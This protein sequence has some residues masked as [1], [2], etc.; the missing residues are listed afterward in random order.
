MIQAARTMTALDDGALA[1]WRVLI[2]FRGPRL[3]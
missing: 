1:H 3:R 2:W